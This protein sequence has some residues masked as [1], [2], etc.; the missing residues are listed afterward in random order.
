[1]MAKTERKRKLRMGWCDQVDRMRKKN[2]PIADLVDLEAI[3]GGLLRTLGTV[4]RMLVRL[5][6]IGLPVMV[7]SQ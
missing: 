6:T 1:M 2:A 7:V 4:S 5:G 3:F